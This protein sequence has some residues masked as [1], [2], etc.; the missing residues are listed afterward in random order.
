MAPVT[1]SRVPLVNGSSAFNGRLDKLNRP[2]LLFETCSHRFL[3]LGPTL[4]NGFLITR[5]LSNPLLLES[6]SS[7]T[8]R[9]VTVEIPPNLTLTN[10]ISG[11]LAVFSIRGR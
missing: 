1:Q 11:G 9:P 10:V 2:Q 6:D 4:S 7:T 8:Y 3:F 5:I